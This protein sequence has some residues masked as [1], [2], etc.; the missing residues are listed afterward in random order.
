M[1]SDLLSTLPGRFLHFLGLRR[2]TIGVLGTVYYAVWG[3]DERSL[4][5]DGGRAGSR[6]G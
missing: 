1:A 6:P 4:K 3:S 2:S 5:A